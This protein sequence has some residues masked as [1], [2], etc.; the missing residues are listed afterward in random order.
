MTPGA[1]ADAPSLR[2]EQTTPPEPR[3]RR[4]EVA[5]LRDY[6]IV[7]TFCALFVVLAISSDSFLTERNLLNI[8]DQWAPLGIMACGMT[9]VLIGGGFD[10]SVGAGF[11]LGGVVAAKVANSTG[12]A[13]GWI[14]GCLVGLAVGGLNGLLVTVV[15]I[16][17]FVATLATGI[18][19]SGAA[20]AVTDGQLIVVDAD[21]FDFLGRGELLGLKVSVYLFLATVIVTGVLLHLS[22]FGRALFA[23]GGNAEAA[24]LSGVR[25]N[26]VRASTYAIVGLCGALAGVITS[27][28]TAVGQPDGGGFADL[29]NIFAAVI[30]GGTSIT[31]GFGAMWRTVIGV[32][33]LALIGNGFNLAN[34]DPVYQSM[35]TGAIILFAVAVD[36]WVSNRR[37]AS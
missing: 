33:L 9:L 13:P 34:I 5:G 18:I 27:S 19:L 29:F 30:I 11:V 20:L 6:G 2:P 1:P 36:V 35:I 22:T 12:I 14:A 23:V 31:G 8:L 37:F 7:I 16:N 24:R 15:R 26:L 4:F 32:L 10:L 25:V 3:K 21:G 28:R 17:A